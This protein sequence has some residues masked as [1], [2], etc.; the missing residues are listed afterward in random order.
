MNPQST[1]VVLYISKDSDLSIWGCKTSKPCEA[2]PALFRISAID[3]AT[4]EIL[5]HSSDRP[6]ISFPVC[7]IRC[8]K[9]CF[10]K[11]LNEISSLY[12]VF[13]LVRI[14][15]QSASVR[16]LLTSTHKEG[17]ISTLFSIVEICVSKVLRLG[18]FTIYSLV[19]RIININLN[20]HL[21]VDWALSCHL[22]KKGFSQFA[23]E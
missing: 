17:L 11:L 20:Y 18:Y 15:L 13:W 6:T 14:V 5:R 22:R 1:S 23:F 10:T 2:N 9:V 3:W 12:V 8:S 7:F 21:S 4:V 19:H 16:L